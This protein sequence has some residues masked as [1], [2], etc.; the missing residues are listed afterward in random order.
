M[1]LVYGVVGIAVLQWM[2]TSAIASLDVGLVLTIGYTAPLLSARSGA[3]SSATST[4][5][6]WSGC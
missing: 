4:S 3:S 5:R 6:A 2:L 1:L